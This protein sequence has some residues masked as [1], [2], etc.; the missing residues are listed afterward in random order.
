[1]CDLASAL[2]LTASGLTRRLDGLVG[3]GAVAREASDHDRRVMYATLTTDGVALLERAAPDH[4]RSVRRHLIDLLTPRQIDAM[5]EAFERV[6]SHL[7]DA[8]DA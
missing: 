5:G 1:M 6:R 2:R 3:S 4:L 8:A 7:R